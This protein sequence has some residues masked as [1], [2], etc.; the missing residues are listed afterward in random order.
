[1]ALKTTLPVEVKL[2]RFERE[3]DAREPFAAWT[4]RE[5]RAIAPDA[6]IEI[7]EADGGSL[8]AFIELDRGSMSPPPEDQ[9]SGLR[10]VRQS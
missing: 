3:A 2:T 9:G 7:T 5:K 8:L 1:M 6:F 10:R 4:S